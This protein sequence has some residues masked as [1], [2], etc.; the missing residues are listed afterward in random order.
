MDKDILNAKRVDDLVDAAANVAAHSRKKIGFRKAMAL[1]GFKPEEIKNHSIYKRVQRQAQSI[2]KSL[3]T[4]PPPASTVCVLANNSSISSLTSA[5][6]ATPAVEIPTNTESPARKPKKKYRRTVKELQRFNAAKATQKERKSI[7]MKEATLRIKRSLDLTAGHAE[8]KSARV[9]VKEVNDI[10]GTNI[11]HNTASRYVREGLAGASPLKRGPESDL[12][13][14]IY[15]ALKGAYTTYLQLEQACC[16]KQSNIRAMVMLVNNTVNAAG[17]AKRDDNLTRKLRHDTA[18][19]FEVGK[20]NVVDRARVQW[21]TSYNLDIWFSTFKGMC[22]DYGFARPKEDGDVD[23]VGELFFF[24]GQLYRIVN[25]DID[26]TTGQRGGRP[27]TVFNSPAVSGGVTAVNKSSYSATL[28]FGSNAA[29]EPLPLH[30]QLKTLA[31]TTEKQRMSINWFEKTQSVMVK[32]GLPEATARPCT[33]GMNEKAGMNTIELEKY[34]FGSIL[35]LFPDVADVPGKRVILKV[36]SG[37]GRNNGPM[38]AKLRVRGVYL[39]PGVPNTTAVTQ[40]TDQNY[41]Q[42]KS[43][44][45]SNIRL[46]SQERFGRKTTMRVT[47]L[48]LLVYGGSCNDT[49]IELPSA[50]EDGFSIR[51]N[52]LA[53]KKCG[54]VPLTRCALQSDKVRHEVPVHGALDHMDNLTD[55]PEVEILKQLEISNRAFCQQLTNS[56]CDGSLLSIRAPV[57]TKSA[58][59]MVKNSKERITA[60]KRAT[61]AGQNFHTT[62]GGHLNSDEFFKAQELRARESKIKL[63]EDAKKERHKYCESQFKAGFIIRK[64]GEL[65]YDNESR[66]SLPE[67]KI[68]CSWKKI[69]TTAT[70]KKD[71]IELYIATEKPRPQKSWTRGEEAALAHLK[72]EDVPMSETLLGV[73]TIEM[74]ESVGNGLLNASDDAI[75]KLES[76][77]QA[78]KERTIP[79]AI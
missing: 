9:I 2:I 71:L 42:F 21:T 22:I 40:E 56:G 20:P 60:L 48:P 45:R 59:I 1:I 64:K 46:L 73:A 43:V 34:I 25:F 37:P 63:M 65:T 49:G 5:T 13:D 4:P 28:I 61:T 76:A 52:L 51:S 26:D 38:L 12:P 8:K 72:D 47:D 58:G 24:P 32:F 39:V 55:D 6:R 14:G 7:A 66:F 62:G 50:F 16:K 44:Y 68:L 17:Y 29:G 79:N 36:D 57:R 53:W 69:K 54:A 23:T 27:P 75:N 74:M 18:N 35:P 33:F 30:F 10:Y 19:E 11:S 67:V 15:K 31:Q 70:K 78:H 41:G 77:I 3:S